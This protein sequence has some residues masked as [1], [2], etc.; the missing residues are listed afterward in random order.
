MQATHRLAAVGVALGFLG[1]GVAGVALFAPSIAHGQN[2]TTTTTSKSSTSA[3]AGRDQ[4]LN[5]ALAPLVKNNTITQAQADAVIKALESA[6][7]TGGTFGGH[8]GDRQ[9]ALGDGFA[10]AAKKIGVSTGTLLNELRSGK[11]I[12]AVAKAHNVTTSAVVDAMVAAEKAELSQAVKE[13]KLTQ[14]QAD[15]QLS[16]ATSRLTD[17][18]N[19]KASNFRGGPGGFGH[20]FGNRGEGDPGSSTSNSNSAYSNS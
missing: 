8:F 6:R 9:G 15:Q 4:Y 1:G 11:T 16:D 10:A 7:P 20:R 19:G 2:G 3:A 18:V 5:Q 13:G 14:A 12:A 17:L